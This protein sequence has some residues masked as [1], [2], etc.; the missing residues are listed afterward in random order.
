[1]LF[2]YFLFMIQSFIYL[3]HS[4]YYELDSAG[5]YFLAITAKILWVLSIVLHIS[6]KFSNPGYLKR[7]KTLKFTKLLEEVLLRDLCEICKLFKTPRAKH[8]DVCG[9]CIDRYDHHCTWI[10]MCLGRGNFK[11]FWGFV[12]AQYLYLIFVI[13][14]A[15]CGIA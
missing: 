5:H 12:I 6:V 2:L 11:R 15:V 9:R 3:W 7:D 14:S 4:I 8:C 10:N 13:L 1:M